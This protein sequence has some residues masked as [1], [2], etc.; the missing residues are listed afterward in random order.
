VRLTP[1]DARTL[2]TLSRARELADEIVSARPTWW[3]GPLLQARIVDLV[4]DEEQ[5]RATKANAY[6]HAFDMGCYR[7]EVVYRLL[8]LLHS[9]NRDSDIDRIRDILRNREDSSAELKYVSA[10]LALDKQDT[11]HALTLARELFETSPRYVDHLTL[12]SFNL[13]AG[14]VD[15]AKA[16]YRRAIELAPG[17]P[18]VWE[19]YVQFLVLTRKTDE[20]NAAIEEAK[21]AL[22]AELVP[23]T[24]ARCLALVGDVTQAESMLQAALKAPESDPATLRTAISFYLSLNRV[25]DATKY[26]DELSA[27]ARGATA[28][29]LAWANRIRAEILVRTGR[30]AD[31]DTALTLIN[32]NLAGEPQSTADLKLKARLLATQPERLGEAV[33]ILEDLHKKRLLEPDNR[34]LLAQ[35]YLAA[36]NSKKYEE[37]MVAL[38][39]E[40]KAYQYSAHYIS[41]LIGNKRFKDA[42]E[43]M[44]ELI[45][46]NPQSVAAMDLEVR[47][48]KAKNSGNSTPELR[49][50]VVA[51]GKKY[52][53][54]MG[55]VAAELAQNGFPKE[56]EAAYKNFVA[57]DPSQPQRELAM[58]SFLSTVPGR[59]DEAMELLAHSWKACKPE[60]VAVAALP[61]YDAPGATEAQRKQVEAW[62]LEAS[63]K[64]P[65]LILLSNKLAVLWIRQGRVDEAEAMYRQLLNSNPS[66]PEALNNLAWLLALRDEK[67]SS[68]AVDL[69]DRA[70][71]LQ[72]PSA[73]LRD[74]R[75][76]ILI[77]GGKFEDAI[78]ELNKAGSTDPR[79]Y[80]VALH[81]AW[82]SQKVGKTDDARKAFQRAVELGWKADLSD[83]LERV[84]IA[85]LR[86]EL[87]L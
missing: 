75:A 69:I 7:S 80:N 3:G 17:T 87:G 66:N 36:K 44:A 25:K 60:Q 18:S 24:L 10:L 6:Q 12:A 54:M 32:R 1:E 70:I 85:K 62:L 43:G 49:D 15:A 30:P 53:D 14:Q 59:A 78:D 20:A 67:N 29:D 31:R 11:K 84:H 73:S 38:L 28:A 50:L 40:T 63:R 33:T 51:R 55:A 68:E 72:G 47:L 34:F 4:N 27:P 58:A 52:P 39:K 37:A 19:Q 23:L 82:A 42:E 5:G 9:L 48:L 81:Q 65:D 86:Q 2:P 74:T 83:P 64:R 56:A 61:L 41:Y 76:V 16:E 45:R 35:C 77:R 57:Q 13:R 8:G 22:R 46:Q 71:R 21:K 79:N 26:L